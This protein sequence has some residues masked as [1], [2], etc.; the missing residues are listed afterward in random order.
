VLNPYYTGKHRQ[1][2]FVLAV[3]PD[4]P[5]GTILSG[6]SI[7]DLHPTILA[8]LSIPLLHPVLNQAV[9][10]QE[11]LPAR[12][13]DA[14]AVMVAQQPPEAPSTAPLFGIMRP[15]GQSSAQKIPR[16]SESIIVA[17]RGVILSKISS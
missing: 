2:A 17:R 10:D 7:L 8:C 6:T 12:T 1:N 5:Q 3:G 4:V 16:S 11:L 14:L 9:A 15:N 13:A